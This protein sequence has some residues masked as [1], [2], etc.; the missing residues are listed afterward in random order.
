MTTKLISVAGL[1]QGSMVKLSQGFTLLELMIAMLLMTLLLAMAVPSYQ[2][3]LIRT[4][5]ANAIEAL[6][7]ASSCQQTIYAAEFHYDTRRCMPAESSGRYSYRMEPAEV[8]ST[9][10]FAVIASPLGVQL[11]DSCNELLLDQSGWREISG[12]E[13]FRRKCWEGR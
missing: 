2:Q 12:P 11:Q 10:V 1:R 7:A 8:A 6:L 13:D 4:H 3:Y 9:T 5:R